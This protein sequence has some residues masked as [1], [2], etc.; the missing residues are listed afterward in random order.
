[1]TDN[2]ARFTRPPRW[3]PSLVA[4]V[5]GFGG[6]A[7][8]TRAATATARLRAAPLAADAEFGYASALDGNL[9]AIGA[10]GERGT[11][12]AAYVYVCTLAGC[13]APSRIAPSDTLAGDR[14]GAAIA[15]SGDTLAV[16]T[17]GHSAGVVHVYTVVGGVPQLQARLDSPSAIADGRFGAALALQGE[18]LVVGAEVAGSAWVY[19]RSA[20]AWGPPQP[21]L[22]M[23]G[24]PRDRYG[25]AVALSGDTLAV[26]APLEATMGVP[27]SYARGAAYVFTLSGGVW[28]QQA[29]LGAAGAANGDLFGL[30]LSLAG[31]RLAVAAPAA[32]LLRG[33]VVLYERNA[34]TWQAVAD[35]AAAAGVPGDRFG[36]SVALATDR[37]VV[38]APLAAET[39]GGAVA[40]VRNA[41]AWTEVPRAFGQASQPGAL[42]GWS[43]AASGA[44]SLVAVPDLDAGGTA[45]AGQV[46]WYEP[47]AGAFGDGFE[48]GIEA[49][50]AAP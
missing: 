5:L 15:L 10:P 34:G 50:L 29:R 4:L 41:G 43:V 24:A 35:L 18:R 27:S 25:A 31:D 11:A 13:A 6:L 9:V 40:F 17:P 21:L 48:P 19:T 47:A 8:P 32:Q 20:G 49:C 44:A 46:A 23:G 14:F 16:G 39:C 7:E 33:K 2:S 30:A 42:Q 12:G 38:G 36:W 26:G 37:L 28:Q 1:M 22:R 45:I 3:A